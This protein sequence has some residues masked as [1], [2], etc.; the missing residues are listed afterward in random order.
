MRFLDTEEQCYEYFLKKIK[1]MKAKID[2][3]MEKAGTNRDEC[4]IEYNKRIKAEGQF[5]KFPVFTEKKSQKRFDI[6]GDIILMKSK[7]E[8]NDELRIAEKEK[9]GYRIGSGIITFRNPKNTRGNS[10][11]A[12]AFIGVSIK[13]I[14]AAERDLKEDSI[15]LLDYLLEAME[16]F[17]VAKGKLDNEFLK[18]TRKIQ[19][20]EI[21]KEI[22]ESMKRN[23][24]L[25]PTGATR[26][27]ISKL[28][29]PKSKLRNARRL[30]PKK[31]KN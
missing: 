11:N 31:T 29:Y 12:K 14:E 17:G 26:H 9:T 19:N 27:A 4:L 13:F 18:E 28:G 8:W 30:A 6:T 24:S 21:L 7:K 16:A 3:L 25:S 15:S 1:N 5:L 10:A 2:F 22:T 23:P 20:E